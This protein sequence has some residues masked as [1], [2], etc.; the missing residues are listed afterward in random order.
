M[1][2]RRGLNISWIME[3][4][5]NHTF[6]GSWTCCVYGLVEPIAVHTN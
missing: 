5:K 1:V 3:Y 2:I 4:T 6:V